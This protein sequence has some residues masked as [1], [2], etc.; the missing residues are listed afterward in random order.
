MAAGL[1][2]T[3][4]LTSLPRLALTAHQLSVGVPTRA[5]SPRLVPAGGADGPLDA[6]VASTGGGVC[7]AGGRLA[8]ASSTYPGRHRSEGERAAAPAA[9]AVQLKQ[10]LTQHVADCVMWGDTHVGVPAAQQ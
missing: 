1:S 6:P 5:A 7:R 9:L 3:L 8:A 2:W 10:E 4:T